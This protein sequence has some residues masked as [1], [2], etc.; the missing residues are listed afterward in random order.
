MGCK[1]LCRF[2]FILAIHPTA[3]SPMLCLLAGALSAGGSEAAAPCISK[4][5]YGKEKGSDL[6]AEE[7]ETVSA[8]TN[9][10]GTATGAVIGNSATDAAQGNLNAQSAVGNNYNLEDA[11]QD[12][13]QIG[14]S[15]LG[16][17][18]AIGDLATPILNPKETLQ[19]LKLL[20]TSPDRL[21]LLQLGFVLLVNER[22][23]EY[24]LFVK[25][26]DVFGQ[27]MVIGRSTGD[28]GLAVGGAAQLVAKSPSALKY[29]SAAL[30]QL[31]RTGSVTIN[32]IKIV[33]VAGKISR[34]ADNY[35]SHV[36]SVKPTYE[37]IKYVQN[38]NRP[39]N[40]NLN[41]W[42][43]M[44]GML[45]DAATKK[46]NFSMGT[47][48]ARQADV[49]G[50]AWVGKGYTIASDGRTLVSADKLRT[51]RPPTAKRS[52]YAH[53]GI[54]ANFERLTP[55]TNR[56]SSNSSIKNTVIS[57]GHLNIKD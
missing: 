44:S 45:R 3:F 48:T 30:T 5:L 42:T 7:K 54:Q 13:K 35:V 23:Q 36:S 43:I 1:K 46:G 41:D 27:S 15:L 20:A 53:T 56:Q 10:L 40:I 37:A 50:K 8:I 17:A 51:Y 2:V 21:E 52:S 16:T 57:N 29:F 33:Y 47:M 25:Q 4:W 31:K 19:S 9:L 39:P 6:T 49:M 24:D 28:I 22:Q 38:L 34:A 26:N 12:I 14:G 55:V 11:E 18:A 32:G